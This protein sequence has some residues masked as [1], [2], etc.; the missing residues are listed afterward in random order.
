MS[1]VTIKVRNEAGVLRR[2]QVQESASFAQLSAQVQGDVKAPSRIQYQDDEGDWIELD[3]DASLGE[4]LRECPFD[5]RGAQRLLRLRT[6][7]AALPA[8]AAAE[9]PTAEATA[10]APRKEAPRMQTTS[11][12]SWPK[13]SKP[14]S[15]LQPH[16]PVLVVGS[17][18]GGA[19]AASR[20]S[21]AGQAVCVL[22][23]GKEMWPGEYPDTA[24]A[25]VPEMQIR[26]PVLPGLIPQV[27]RKDGFYDFR[28][29]EGVVA[30]VGCG[31]GGGSLVNSGV[32][33]LPDTRVFDDACWPQALRE[34]KDVGLAAGFARAS[35]ML[36]PAQYPRQ[37]TAPLARA[38]RMEEAAAEL[39]AKGHAQASTELAHVN[40]AFDARTNPAGVAQPACA[41]CGDC[42]TGCNTGA[43]STTLMNYLPDAYQH[44][45]DMF[46]QI[47]VLSFERGAGGGGWVVHCEGTD[48]AH[49]TKLDVTC[50]TLILAAGTLGSTEILLR[51]RA[52]GIVPVSP[53]VG[54]RFGTDG[55]FFS[56]GYNGTEPWNALGYGVGEKAAAERAKMG[57]DSGPCITSVCDMRDPATPVRE[58]FIIEDMAVPGAFVAPI[59]GVF[60]GLNALTG[61]ASDT[62]PAA[63]AAALARQTQ[64]F[65]DGPF[66]QG[67]ALAN[68]VM[69]G[70]MS[71]DDQAGKLSLEE[72]VLR[73]KWPGPAAVPDPASIDGPLQQVTAMP[74]MEGSYCKNPFVGPY[75]ALGKDQGMRGTVHPFG[76]CCMGDD[77]TSGAVN[78]KGQVFSGATGASVY[79]DLYVIDGATV[80]MSLGVN[81]LMT[82]SAIA[83]RAV[84]LMAVDR[85]WTID[86]SPIHT[87]SSGGGGGAGGAGGTGGAAAAATAGPKRGLP[88]RRVMDMKTSQQQDDKTGL[89]W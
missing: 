67:G 61:Q 5:A 21:R 50:D 10:A 19:I 86:Y 17:G 64:S 59:L 81:P 34:D 63:V 14:L 72:D 35:A 27:G 83:E 31:L 20:L 74:S 66:S 46:C 76:G 32:A 62:D 49:P 78:H 16:Y 68:S 69:F 6:V 40:V 24:A 47:E 37:A 71:F 53:Q 41:L 75:K 87:C 77:A 89:E 25:A 38:T 29:E 43:K 33:I 18:Y 44:G 11:P 70:M 9:A 23:R 52:L 1:A 56:V 88:L 85:G 3:S 39:R 2:F 48:P 45:A 57:G 80:C 84:A 15:E 30:W 79:D 26:T 58:G 28:L 4:A 73:I 7:A 12:M 82:I 36:Q 8:A 60:A 55:D 65:Q 54:L 13:L 42:N 51:N 22:E